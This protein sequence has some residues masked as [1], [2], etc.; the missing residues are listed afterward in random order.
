[1]GIMARFICQALR[2]AVLPVAMA[3]AILQAGCKSDIN[4]QLLERELR[5][6]EDQI[7]LLQDELQQKCARLDRT[8][9]ENNSLKKQLGIVDADGSLPSRIHVPPGVASPARPFASPPSGVSAPVFVPPAIGLPAIEVPGLP[10]PTGVPSIGSDAPSR[11]GEPKVPSPGSSDG[12]RFGPPARFDAPTLD[13]VPPLPDEPAA[14]GATGP[15]GRRLSH[16][17]SLAGEGRITHLVLNPERCE[18]FDGNG[19]GVSEGLA[20]VFEPRDTD[21]R[22]VT[23]S[24]DVSI[25]VYAPTSQPDVTVAEGNPAPHASDEGVCIATWNIPSAEAA[26][27]FRRTSRARGL[28]F[29]LPW[30]GQPPEASHLRVLVQFTTFD[31]TVFQTDGTVADHSKDAA[32]HTP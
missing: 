7:Y 5:M 16:E 30:P 27:H 29:V 14:R 12:L 28:H 18:C 22:L 15:V 23:S 8:A 11:S 3:A 13:G 25:N 21:E 9:G 17:E 32:A 24:G 4:Q 31:G 2:R 20:V 26:K 19:D 6:Q 1:M 10:E